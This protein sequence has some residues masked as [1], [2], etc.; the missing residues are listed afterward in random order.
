MW[1]IYDI[2]LSI[3]AARLMK[4]GVSHIRCSTCAGVDLRLLGVAPGVPLSAL[5]KFYPVLWAA[6]ALNFASGVLLFI[7][8][9]YKA[10]TNPLFYVKLGLIAAAIYL[11]VRIRHSILRR[12]DANAPLS[13]TARNGSRLF[14]SCAGPA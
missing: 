2:N 12:P 10:A 5:E 13:F 7:G 6:L 9:P 14:R 3:L 4:S 11:A 8:Y 1:L